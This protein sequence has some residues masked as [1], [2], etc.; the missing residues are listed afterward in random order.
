MPRNDITGM[1]KDRPYAGELLDP[2]FNIHKGAEILA[3]YISQT[4]GLR[5][6]L[7]SYYGTV[8]EDCEYAHLVLDILSD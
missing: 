4:G 6:G 5:S 1:F 8:G 3:N 2:T 7:C